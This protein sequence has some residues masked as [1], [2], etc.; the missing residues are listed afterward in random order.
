MEGRSSKKSEV[1]PERLQVLNAASMPAL[2]IAEEVAT[3]KVSE[4]LPYL[5]MAE[6][7]P[8]RNFPNRHVKHS[9]KSC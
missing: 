9:G 3:N 7:D 6:R 5:W 8:E 2:S 1:G 4:V